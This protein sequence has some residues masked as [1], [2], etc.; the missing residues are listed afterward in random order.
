MTIERFR[1]RNKTRRF[2][3]LK[4]PRT[5]P[6]GPFGCANSRILCATFVTSTIL[7]ILSTPYSSAQTSLPNCPTNKGAFK[8]GCLKEETLQNGTKLIL[9]YKDDMPLNR[10]KL[11][12]KDGGLYEGEL[13][14][15]TP[16]GFG[17]LH[18]PRGFLVEGNW[19]NDKVI[20]VSR[21]T[22]SSGEVYEGEFPDGKMNG[23][24]KI[25]FPDGSVYI[26]DILQGKRHGKGNMVY[27]DGA[28]YEGDFQSDKRT[29][30]GR[31]QFA[32][33]NFYAGDFKANLFHGF[34]TLVGGLFM[35]V[36][37]FTDGKPNGNGTT[38]SLETNRKFS[39]QYV[40]GKPDGY[41]IRSFANGEKYI[42][43]FKEG[44]YNGEGVFYAKDGTVLQSGNWAMGVFKSGDVKNSSPALTTSRE[45]GSDGSE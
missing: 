39:G 33:G 7:T 10:G 35:Y 11:K 12:Y 37:E 38:I 32:S 4:S 8:S 6:I 36:G 9:E 28:I 27:K 24:G 20:G 21:W 22:F 19:Q 25:T 26:G 1:S 41:G 2:P 42:G 18:S 15:N 17:V 44:E 30:Y 23:R 3:W 14:K 5:K 45:T 34:G 40:N 43:Y 29:G 31:I 13:N 16:Y